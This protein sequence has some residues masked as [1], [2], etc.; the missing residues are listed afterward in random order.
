[1]AGRPVRFPARFAELSG[2]PLVEHG[3]APHLGSSTVADVVRDAAQRAPRTGPERP[4]GTGSAAAAQGPLSGLRV[5]DL[6]TVFAV[7]YLGALLRD[8]GADVLKIEAPARLDQSRSSFGVSF[9]NRPDGDYWNRASTFQVLNRGKESVVLD[10][11][12]VEGR[13][14]LR[15]LVAQ[16][17]I[18]LDNF[19][20]RVMRKWRT[21]YD[22][23]RKVN[24]RLVMLSNTGYGA[25]GPWTSFKA[26]G[27]TIE[28]TMGLTSVT[29]YAG[30]GPTKAGQSYPDFLACWTGLL[31]TLSALVARRETGEGQWIDLGM[32]QLGPTV[33]P[34]AVL[35]RQALGSEPARAGNREAGAVISDLFETAEHGRLLAVSVAS[36]GRLLDLADAAPEIAQV[37][38]VA[39]LVED[40]SAPIL[41]SLLADW[42]RAR[43]WRD[44]ATVLQAAGIAAGPVMD[45]RDL[46]EDPHL[47]EREFYE[48]VDAGGPMGRRPLIGQPFTW[49]AE[50][51]RVIVRGRAPRFG[52]HNDHVL[53]TVAGLDAAAVDRLRREGRVT[54]APVNPPAARPLPLESMAESGSLRL[55]R[56][57]LHTL[58]RLAPAPDPAGGGDCAL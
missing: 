35:G 51:S 53:R 16:A 18:L 37:A 46:A 15:A 57:Y 49:T 27:T 44:A 58:M 24:P 22:E 2:T 39:G 23:L 50:R 41:R 48:W 38:A 11:D 5:V 13:D 3:P 43:S 8:M 56:D 47:R 45:A 52:E 6:S 19:T 14:V 42:I 36:I 21:T 7:P 10:L 33:I 12:T 28:A 32:Y 55:E 26:Q 9:D 17:D 31:A 40:E 30:G 1:M 54:D 29:G 20:P 25:S 4:D 34:E